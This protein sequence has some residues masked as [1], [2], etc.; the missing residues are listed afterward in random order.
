M[1]EDLPTSKGSKATNQTIYIEEQMPNGRVVTR[2]AGH[3]NEGRF[4]P[5][6]RPS[7]SAKMTVSVSVSVSC[8]G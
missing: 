4:K 2:K 5:Y 3:V 8:A 1:A 7:T 6:P